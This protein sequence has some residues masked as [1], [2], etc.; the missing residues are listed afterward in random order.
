MNRGF[1]EVD[2]AM[3]YNIKIFRKLIERILQGY[4]KGI[5]YISLINTIVLILLI[6]PQATS[7]V[8]W[9]H[10]VKQ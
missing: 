9:F 2:L 8:L 3:S 1:R 10:L 4:V 7:L 5:D 6:A